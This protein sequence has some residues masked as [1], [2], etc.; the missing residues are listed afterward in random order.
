MTPAQA[1]DV[2]SKLIHL[3]NQQC[4]LYRQLQSLSTKQSALVEEDEPETLLRFLA[5]RQ[6]LI[7][8]LVA[9]N[10]ELQPIRA[11]WQQVAQ[12]LPATQRAEAETLVSNVEDIL[13]D[14]LTKD[15]RD[16]QRL[17]DRRGTVAADIKLA[18]TG[19]RVNQAYA[20][21]GQQHSRY[22]DSQ[23]Q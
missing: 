6:R 3:L 9:L 2:G 4:L 1:M 18:T 19:K 21:A 22:F 11:D 8:R 20:N 23:C 13:R 7:D 16:T 12:S 14:I 17:T 10:R 15:K 5:G